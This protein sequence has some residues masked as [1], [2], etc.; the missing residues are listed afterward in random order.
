MPSDQHALAV[1]LEV[2]RRFMSVSRNGVEPVAPA[3]VEGGDLPTGAVQLNVAFLADSGF[4]IEEAP[5]RFKPTPVAMQLMNTL[6]TDEQ[7]GRRLLR[8]LVSKLWFGRVVT[9]VR[10][11]DPRAGAP[12]VLARLI[13]EAA[14]SG[15]EERRAA[16]VLLEYLTFS[17]LVDPGP[18]EAHDRE[19]PPASGSSGR[20]PGRVPVR[21]TGPPKGSPSEWK[22]VR[23]DDF[24]LKIRSDRAAVRR[25]RRQ[26]DLLE[27]EL[28]E[29]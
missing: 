17:G 7:R 26:L 28:A 29:N 5:G 3:A 2:L 21:R 24:E 8:S 9:A 19:G 15:P 18:A 23:T 25:L 12:E 6:S 13:D 14:A 11:S 16:N 4:L 22:V 10:Q 20:I 27:E 1:H